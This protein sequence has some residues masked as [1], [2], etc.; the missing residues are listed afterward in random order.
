MRIGFKLHIIRQTDDDNDRLIQTIWRGVH[1]AA[2]AEVSCSYPHARLALR[3]SNN[4]LVAIQGQKNLCGSSGTQSQAKAILL[5][6]LTGVP[7]RVLQETRLTVPL[8][9]GPPISIRKK[10]LQQLW[11]GALAPPSCS[12][13]CSAR[14]GTGP[15]PH[16]QIR[17]QWFRGLLPRG[18]PSNLMVWLWILKGSCSPF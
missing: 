6:G 11:K 1:K 16:C 9:A 2:E 3:P 10:I 8:K 5:S 14:V 15:A 17:K 7:P 13:S 12:R 4:N 18:Q